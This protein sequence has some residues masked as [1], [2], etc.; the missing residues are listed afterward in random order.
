MEYQQQVHCDIRRKWWRCPPFRAINE[1]GDDLRQPLRRPPQCNEDLT[2]YTEEDKGDEVNS[3]TIVKFNDNQILYAHWERNKYSVTFN[4]GH[5]KVS[6]AYPYEDPINV[7]ET[8]SK[9][10]Y[11]I[12]RWYT[13]DD[14][15]PCLRHSACRTLCD[16]CRD[17]RWAT[18]GVSSLGALD[19]IHVASTK[20]G[21]TVDRE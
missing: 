18:C 2:Y 1:H 21:F 15:D 11:K 10:F 13:E 14:Q 3:S 12:E 17:C 5:K 16:I 9:L 4:F 6:E 20:K 7:S 8:G 19:C